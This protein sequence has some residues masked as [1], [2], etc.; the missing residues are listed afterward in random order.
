M[1]HGGDE[2]VATRAEPT[3]SLY[4]S[5]RECHKHSVAARVHKV[6]SFLHQRRGQ[7]DEDVIA[8]RVD[9]RDTFA[10][11]SD[12]Q[13]VAARRDPFAGLCAALRDEVGKYDE[14]FVTNVCCSI[15]HA[16]ISK[17]REGIN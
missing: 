3:S 16:V 6:A 11:E 13:V 1:W 8:P 15:L 5:L 14:Y 7:G 4:A 17:W 9:P 12:E 2:G 10:R